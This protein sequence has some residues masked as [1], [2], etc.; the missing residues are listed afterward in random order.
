MSIDIVDTTKSALGSLNTD[1]G[2][3]VIGLLALLQIISVA[4]TFALE[5]EQL[6]LAAIGGTSYIITSL[7]GIIIT[8]GVLRS[9][10][11]DQM[12]RSQYTSNLLWPITRFFG[13]QTTTVILATLV[14]LIGLIPLGIA[15]AIGAAGLGMGIGG[16]TGASGITAAIG[17]I[18][19][20]IGI[21]L[22]VGIFA[23]IYATLVISLPMIASDNRRVFEA[24]DL[25]IQRTKDNRLR[26]IASIITTIL[27]IIGLGLLGGTLVLILSFV[28]EPLAAATGLAGYFLISAAFTAAYLSL[29]TELNQRLPEA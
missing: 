13:A 23:Y 20:I 9:F 19:G 5:A 16:M 17:A 21:G 18:L 29:L 14:S 6:A 22:G 28:Y 8:L 26:I 1:T 24:L 11:T 2:R 27:P 3:K 7:L 12:E 10:D 25:S 15:G 4:S